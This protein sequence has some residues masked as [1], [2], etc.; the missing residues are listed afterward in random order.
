MNVT[1]L[2]IDKFYVAGPKR[3]HCENCKC[4]FC[5]DTNPNHHLNDFIFIGSSDDMNKFSLAYDYLDEYTKP[6]ECPRW[7][8]MSSHFL[9]VWHLDKLGILNQDTISESF[10]TFDE[11]YDEDTDY[12][13]FR[14]RGKFST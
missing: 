7:M 4:L 10:T 8:L 1:K 12:H 2:K 13:I 11:G 14:D 9:S 6:N 5:D 3:H